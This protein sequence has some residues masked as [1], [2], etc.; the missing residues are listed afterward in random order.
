MSVEDRVRRMLNRAVIAEP[1]PARAPLEQVFR[2]RRRRPLVAATVALALLLSTAVV[3]VRIHERATQ[4]SNPSTNL[5]P[6]GWKEYRDERE[7]YRFR[8][9]PGWVVK[10]N[11]LFQ[12]QALILPPESAAVPLPVKNDT[13][14][15]FLMTAADVWDYYAVYGAG[16]PIAGAGRLPGG[17]AFLQSEVLQYQ[18]RKFSRYIID[19][20]RFC[21][22][23]P[24]PDPGM[25]ATNCRAHTQHVTVDGKTALW[26]RY[27]AI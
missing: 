8:Y 27:H 15:P 16:Y 14:L 20:G 17:Q 5:V 22:T 7:N 24:N 2:R 11:G 13:Q 23:D 4:L 12:G 9:P 25:P 19:W 18:A 1:P 21:M 6:K 26:D 10:P 3:V